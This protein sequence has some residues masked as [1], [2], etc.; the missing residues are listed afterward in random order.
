M[1]HQ[2]L[3]ADDDPLVRHILA[4]QAVACGAECTQVDNGL[5]ALACLRQRRYDLV[6]LDVM[7]PELD[8]MATLARLRRLPDAPPVLMATGHLDP[9][10][11]QR[12]AAAG[13][14]GWLSK[15]LQIDEVRHTLRRFL[16]R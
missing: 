1:R 13:A 7:M 4:M 9:L 14:A 3:I 2:V 16:T 15:P 10:I 12:L 6:I 8:G 5:Q 11:E